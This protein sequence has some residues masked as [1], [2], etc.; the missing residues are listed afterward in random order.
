MNKIFNPSIKKIN[1]LGQELR[2]QREYYCYKNN[3]SLPL[4][5]NSTDKFKDEKK[6]LQNI[7]Y[8]YMDKRFIT[9]SEYAT[10]YEILYAIE[11]GKS[12][13]KNEI[14][15]PNA[16]FLRMCC[17]FKIY[18]FLDNMTILE[19]L[20]NTYKLEPS[21]ESSQRIVKDIKEDYTIGNL[22][23]NKEKGK[24]IKVNIKY[25]RI[26]CSK[27]TYLK[28]FD[29]KSEIEEINE[30]YNKELKTE[31]YLYH[32]QPSFGYL[33]K[34]INLFKNFNIDVKIKNNKNSLDYSIKEIEKLIKKNMNVLVEIVEK[35]N[36]SMEN[37]IKD[38]ENEN[39]STF[40]FITELLKM[41]DEIDI[42]DKELLKFKKLMQ[43]YIKL[44]NRRTNRVLKTKME[45]P[46]DCFMFGY[47]FTEERQR[48]QE[49]MKELS[50][51]ERYCTSLELGRDTS[52]IDS[53]IN[54]TLQNIPLDTLLKTLEYFDMKNEKF[55][56]VLNI[57]KKD[58]STD[59]INSSNFEVF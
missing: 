59:S 11:N 33:R 22:L 7:L 43:N 55:Y 51:I 47:I 56:N 36:T 13:K 41:A 23:R 27:D 29:D 24:I 10:S 17:L 26:L 16:Y 40:E 9:N 46:E 1:N 50:Q 44:Y 32:Y 49:K 2:F 52:Y 39:I 54:G 28:F 31:R 42:N 3:T 8:E 30:R 5:I 38:L 57:I 53:F 12:K 48:L 15:N 58:F 45:H 35:N 14:Y 20:E 21:F 19:L 25:G 6:S 18:G 37:L 4:K 34:V